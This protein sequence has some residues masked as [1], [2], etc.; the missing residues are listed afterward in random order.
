MP[1]LTGK[2]VSELGFKK[3]VVC[4]EPGFGIPAVRKK[5]LSAYKCDMYEFWA[6]LA[7][8]YAISCNSEDYCGMHEVAPDISIYSDDLVDPD[9]KEPIEVKDGAVGEGVVTSLDREGLPLIKY[10]LGDIIQVYTSPCECGYKG[11]RVKVI[12]RSDDLLIVKGVNIYPSAIRQIVGSFVPQVTGAVKIV[13]TEKPPRVAPPLKIKVEYG[14]NVQDNELDELAKKIKVKM[15]EK[16]RVT[17]EIEWV[18][19]GTLGRTE[20]KTQMFEKRYVE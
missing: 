16:N 5:L 6:P 11:N 12:G 4:G 17:P 10:A 7:E 19:P 2:P 15:H 8:A 1:E 18:A 20:K 3:V 13:L 9:T 14:Y